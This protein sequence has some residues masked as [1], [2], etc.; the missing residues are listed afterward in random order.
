MKKKPKT[1]IVFALATMA[2]ASFMVACASQTVQGTIEAKPLSDKAQ[3]KMV[4]PEEKERP[5]QAAPIETKETR[6]EVSDMPS[7]KNAFRNYWILNTTPIFDINDKKV[8]E[9]DKGKIVRVF[10]M[11][12]ERAFIS[13]DRTQWVRRLSLTTRHPDM[14]RASETA[15]TGQERIDK[16]ALIEQLKSGERQQNPDKN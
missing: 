1:R 9:L 13:E 10:H 5:V 12:D 7:S 11:G 3:A 8:G 15:T 6:V 14:K 2:S 16:D 4:S